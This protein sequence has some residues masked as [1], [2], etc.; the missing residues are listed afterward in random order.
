MTIRIVMNSVVS[1]NG[2]TKVNN[3]SGVVITS[4]LSYNGVR[5]INYDSTQRRDIG[6]L[7]NSTTLES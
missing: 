4:G 5:K 7:L 3:D 6:N 1:D 2:A